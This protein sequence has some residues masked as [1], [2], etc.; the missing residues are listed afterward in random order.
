MVDDFSEPIAII[1]DREPERCESQQFAAS[2]E[3]MG[4]RNSGL[5]PASGLFS[6]RITTESYGS[7]QWSRYA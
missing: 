1:P 3:W 5:L 6:G 2:L 7:P 4:I